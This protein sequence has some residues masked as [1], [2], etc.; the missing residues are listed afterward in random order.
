MK[1]EKDRGIILPEE[2]EIESHDPSV[3]HFKSQNKRNEFLRS[4]EEDRTSFTY[5]TIH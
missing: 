5:S 4:L 2:D 1:D 3:E